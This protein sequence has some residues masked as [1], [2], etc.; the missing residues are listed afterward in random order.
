MRQAIAIFTLLLLVLT[1]CE[2]KKEAEMQAREAYMEGQAQAA[3]QWREQQPP[4]VFMRGPVRH[5]AVPWTDGLTLAQAIVAAEYTGYMNPIFIRV[6][7]NGQMVE[8]M[9]GID[10]LH[11]HDFPLEAGDVVDIVP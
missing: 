2:T 10:L 7:R 6:I 11:H 5:P 1:G 9:K 3:K 8:E 4:Q